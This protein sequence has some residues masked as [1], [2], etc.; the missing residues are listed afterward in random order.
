MQCLCVLI[1][2]QDFIKEGY[3]KVFIY[4]MT[5]IISFPIVD[6]KKNNFACCE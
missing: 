5:M 2:M 6:S 3:I 4:L 1:R